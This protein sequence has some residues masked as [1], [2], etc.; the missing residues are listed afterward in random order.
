MKI[1]IISDSLALGGGAEKFSASL[2]IEFHKRNHEIYHLTLFDDNPKYDFKGKYFTFNESHSKNI[3]AKI[4][5]F[6]ATS[7][8]IQKICK[9][10]EIDLIV[11]VGEVANFRTILSKYLFRNK[12][13][14]YASH[15]IYPESYLNNKV[16]YNRIKFSYSKADRIICVS[17]A[18]ENVLQ[19]KYSL[20]NTL[21]IYNM[22]DIQSNLKKSNELLPEEYKE[23]FYDSF[24]FINIGRLNFQKGHWFLLRS[25][26]KVTCKYKDVK[27]CILGDGDL[28]TKL[29]EM[30][31]ELNLE[32]NVFLIGNQEN[33]YPFLKKSDCLILSSLLE[34]FPLTLIE[35]LS[36]NLPVISTDCKTGPRECLCPSLDVN[37]EI[38]YPYFGEYGI[39][40]KPFQKKWKHSKDKLDTAEEMISNLMIKM[41]EDPILR[42]KYS[43]GLNRAKDF[44]KEKIIQYWEKLFTE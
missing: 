30:I 15:H 10:N 17:K 40:T 38:E 19:E 5:D 14:I 42:K 44:D 33:V 25:F 37:K 23:I 34:G 12:T 24:I 16:T 39:L 41:I 4:K 22:I 1:L 11:S 27:M 35:T 18:I 32:K 29:T 8:K 43:N 36:L 7:Y 3:L 9:K 20:N 26:K 28:K 21:T 31:I 2:G 13:K 6:F